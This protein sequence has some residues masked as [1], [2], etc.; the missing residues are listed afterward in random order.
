MQLYTCVFLW[1][2]IHAKSGCSDMEGVCFGSR[3]PVSV[4]SPPICVSPYFMR[5]VTSPRKR[6][7]SSLKVQRSHEEGFSR[8]H[9]STTVA[10]SYIYTRVGPG[11]A[12]PKFPVFVHL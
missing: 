7:A 5:D 1:E 12:V 3:G 2:V 9:G 8:R 4:E 6:R 11:N 10:R